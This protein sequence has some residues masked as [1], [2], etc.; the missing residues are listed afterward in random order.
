MMTRKKKKKKSADPGSVHPALQQLLHDHSASCVH[1]GLCVRE[2]AF[3]QEHGSPGTIAASFDQR[4]FGTAFGCSLCGLCTAV[5]PTKIGLDPAALFLAIRREAV[6]RGLADFSRHRGIL[7]YERAGSS[8][9]LTFHGLPRGCDTVFFPGCALPGTR[10]TR[11]RQLFDHL[12]Q[13]IPRLGMVLDCCSKPSHDLGR[14]RYFQTMFRKLTGSLLE[15]GVKNVLVACPNCHRIF[16][17]YG[18]GLQV[19]SVYEYLDM[20]ALPK[21]PDIAAEITIH[22]PCGTRLRTDIHQVIRRLAGKKSLQVRE[23]A[24]HGKRTLCCGEGA[25]PAVSVRNLPAN[26]ESAAAGKPRVWSC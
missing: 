10:P 9:L 3:L 23:M 4:T 5:C 22:D 19:T 24:H 17:E 14:E 16:S 1:C 26:G 21:T 6:A 13:T 7:F 20:T 8:P 2:C 12:R 18:Q 25:R 15:R 11:V